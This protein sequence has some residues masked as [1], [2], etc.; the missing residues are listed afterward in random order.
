MASNQPVPRRTVPR[1]AAHF[2]ARQLLTMPD[3][4]RSGLAGAHHRVLFTEITGQPADKWEEACD[5]AAA[6]RLPLLMLAPIVT[7][8]EQ[9][10]TEGEGK[11]TWRTDR[12]SPCPRQAAGRY[13]SFLASL[14]YPLSDVEQAVADGIPYTGDSPFGDLPGDVGASHEPVPG[15]SVGEGAPATPDGRAEGTGVGDLSS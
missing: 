14:G 4:L 11:N 8:Y 6:A 12:Y 13:L 2:I 15:D 3:P 7:A 10:M 9:A 5:T 1:E